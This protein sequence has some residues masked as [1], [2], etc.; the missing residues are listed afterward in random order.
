VAILHTFVVTGPNTVWA[1]F[2]IRGGLAGH[3]FQ[4]PGEK[5]VDAQHTM[6]RHYQAV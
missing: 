6:L 3:P 1:A 5:R 4:L 2:D